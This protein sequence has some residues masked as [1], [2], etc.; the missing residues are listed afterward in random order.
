MLRCSLRHL[1][2]GRHLRVRGSEKPGDLFGQGLVGGKAGELA[3]PQ[4]EIT[5]GQPVEIGGVVCV[6]GHARTIADR[7][8]AQPSHPQKRTLSHCGIGA[9]VT[10]PM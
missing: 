5:A 2:D 4:V 6:R 9:K 10:A 7:S 1:K 8:P 3:L